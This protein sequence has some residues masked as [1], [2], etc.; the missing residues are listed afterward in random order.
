MQ[1]YV[2][3]GL[4]TEVDLE[5]VLEVCRYSWSLTKGYARTYLGGGRCNSKY[6]YLHQFIGE[7]MGLIGQVDHKDRN[8]FNNSRFNLRIASLSQ[9]GANQDIRSN[10][11]SGYKGVSYVRKGNKWNAR[12]KINYESIS[13]GSFNTPEEA[14]LAYNQAAIQYFGEF[15]VL[16]KI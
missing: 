8:S 5:D 9:N 12:I 14:A 10:N 4:Y 11:T 7:R 15:A 6:I 3:H 2:G 16:N 1:L 13:L